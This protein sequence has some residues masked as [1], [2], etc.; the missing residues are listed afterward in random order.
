MIQ[1]YLKDIQKYAEA[2][3]YG[4]VSVNIKRVGRK[5]TQIVLESQ[6]TLRYTD[7]ASGVEDI[8]AILKE[9]ADGGYSGSTRVECEYKNGKVTMVTIHDKIQTQY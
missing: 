7:E 5:T 2:I 9:L 4:E 8:H 6:E 1:T 3:P